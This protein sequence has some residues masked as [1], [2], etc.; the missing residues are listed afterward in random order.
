MKTRTNAFRK[1]SPGRPLAGAEGQTREMLLEAATRLFAERGVAATTF[2][3]IAERAG[4]TPAMVHYYFRDRDALIDAVVNE[5]LAPL[6]LSVWEPV[7]PGDPAPAILRGV[8]ERL[9]A[10]IERHPWVPSTWMREVLNED[11]LLRGRV[12][13]HLPLDKVR[14]LGEA[15]L[16]GQKTGSVHADL[17]PVLII[18]STLGLAMLHSATVR[19]FAEIF[20]REVPDR[21]TL[22][23]HITALL[24]HGVERDV[25]LS[26]QTAG[27]TR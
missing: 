7:Q 8:I 10:G 26:R 12:L 14:L 18:F 23:R 25:P 17:D 21:K 16:R 9:L 2:A 5:R 4:L 24:L 19:F 15:M 3:L 20:H 1:R 22:Q 13:R 11:G 27:H 6:I